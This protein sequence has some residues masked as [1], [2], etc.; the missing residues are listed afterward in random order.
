M[1]LKSKQDLRPSTVVKLS[2][3]K[4]P[5][6]LIVQQLAVGTYFSLKNSAAVYV[7]TDETLASGYRCFVVNTGLLKHISSTTEVEK[8]YSGVSINIS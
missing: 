6:P 2:V 1:S 3:P 4:D 7:K 8:V 5:A